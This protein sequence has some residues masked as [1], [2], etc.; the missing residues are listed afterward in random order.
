MPLTITYNNSTIAT[1]ADAGTK[2]LLTRGTF[3]NYDVGLQDGTETCE[4]RYIAGTL[5]SYYDPV[6]TSIGYFAFGR[7]SS[8]LSTVNFPNVT[9]IGVSAFYNCA[10]LTTLSFPKVVTIES[11]AFY[12]CRILST[13]AFPSATTIGVNAFGNCSLLTTIS[14]PNATNISSSAFAICTSLSVVSFPKA[15]VIGSRAFY[16]CMQLS[17]LYLTGSSLVTLENSTAFSMTP[18]S[19]STYLGHFGSIYVPNSLLANY[20]AAANWSLYSSR[21]VG[22]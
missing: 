12:L 10:S 9:N 16:N 15:T 14:F 5:V 18:I 4:D 11:T 13:V 7:F 22:V 19:D 8:V 1:L 2:T 6:A 17:A 20:K 3:L 21:F